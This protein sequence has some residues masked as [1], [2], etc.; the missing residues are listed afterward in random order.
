MSHYF[1]S[2]PRTVKRWLLV[3]F[4][5]VGLIVAAVVGLGFRGDITDPDGSQVSAS[6]PEELSKV[7]TLQVSDMLGR[8]LMMPVS[9]RVMARQEAMVSAESGGK[10]EQLT[11]AAGQTVAAGETLAKLE[12]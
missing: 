10:V 2:R 5:A 1:N 6:S 9:G 12:S 7:E 8:E 4:A 11:V 3:A